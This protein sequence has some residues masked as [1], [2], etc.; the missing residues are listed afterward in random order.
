VTAGLKLCGCRIS[1]VAAKDY[2]G[3]VFEPDR[4]AED[5]EAS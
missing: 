2:E 5:A 1:E 3:F 4:R